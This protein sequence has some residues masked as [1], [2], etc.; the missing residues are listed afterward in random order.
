MFS[1]C[2]YFCNR[3]SHY[4]HTYGTE[5]DALFSKYSDAA[6]ARQG[7]YVSCSAAVLFGTVLIMI[8]LCALPNKRSSEDTEFK[9]LCSAVGLSAA[10]Y[11]YATVY[12][13]Y[14]ASY[15]W[16]WLDKLHGDSLGS[17]TQQSE[18]LAGILLVCPCIA[19]AMFLAGITFAIYCFWPNCDEE[20]EDYQL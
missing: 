18:V 13:V 9:L 6:V 17:V 12:S 10:S 3:I 20:V 7:L 5:A 14:I 1:F 19:G 8:L 16:S 15:A 4:F 11:F 2:A